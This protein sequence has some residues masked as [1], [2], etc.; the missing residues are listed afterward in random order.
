MTDSRA[1]ILFDGACVLCSA[2]AQFIL[3]H[4]HARRF[5]LAAMQGEAGAALSR[6]H[7]VD[8]TDPDTIIVVDGANALRHSDAV[9]AIASGLGWPWRAAVVARLIPQRL[10][11]PMYRWV[12]RRR[13]RLFG[14][15]AICWTPRPEH[16]NRVL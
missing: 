4:D 16:A 1:I 2:S 3:R 9:I 13:Y 11:D 15:R 8:P 5:R 12:A 10:R 6:L 7:G 14:K